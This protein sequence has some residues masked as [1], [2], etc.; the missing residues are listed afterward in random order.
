MH[1]LCVCVCFS[2]D[3]SDVVIG[4]NLGNIKMIQNDRVYIVNVVYG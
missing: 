4:F 1:I 3:V 2:I